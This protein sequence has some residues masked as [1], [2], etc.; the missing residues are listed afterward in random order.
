[1][2]VTS[3]PTAMSGSVMDL[4]FFQESSGLLRFKGLIQRGQVMCVETCPSPR[5]FSRLLDKSHRRVH[6]ERRP[7]LVW[8]VAHSLSH[9]ASLSRA[10]ST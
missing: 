7:N 1:M 8:F 10:Q 5:Q 6:A 3:E 4:D 9:A 2:Q